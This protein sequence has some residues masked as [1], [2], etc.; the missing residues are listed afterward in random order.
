MEILNIGKEKFNHQ[1]EYNK[2]L[3]M[4]T[5][6]LCNNLSKYVIILHY[7]SSDHVNDVEVSIYCIVVLIWKSL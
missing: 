5:K 6:N 4:D 1:Y 2:A 3:S 7:N